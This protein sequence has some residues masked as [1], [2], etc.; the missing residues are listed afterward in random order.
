MRLQILSNSQSLRLAVKLSNNDS[1]ELENSLDQSRITKREIDDYT[2]EA[3]EESH[4]FEQFQGASISITPSTT[5]TVTRA[6]EHKCPSCLKRVMSVKS[7]N[8]HMEL[9]EI[10]VLDEFFSQFQNIYSKRR[11]LKLTMN[12]F[13]L[14]AI[15]LVFDTQKKL[16]KIVFSHQID[17]D[18]IS[19]ELPEQ[20][21][22]PPFGSSSQRRSYQS[23]DNGYVSDVKN[24]NP[25]ITR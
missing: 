8:E 4:F 16:S 22:P 2:S 11:G 5:R 21:M 19:N 24:T 1:V 7:L 9:C 23:P 25:F 6:M 12:E 15:K 18:S 14:Y 20:D 3:I 10:I 17:V 13:V